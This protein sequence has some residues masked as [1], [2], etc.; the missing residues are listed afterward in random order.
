MLKKNNDLGFYFILIKWIF[1]LF[2]VTL[3]RTK[4]FSEEKVIQ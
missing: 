1:Q 2:R 3:K 4:L